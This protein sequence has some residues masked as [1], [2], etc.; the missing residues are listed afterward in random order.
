[1]IEVAAYSRREIDTPWGAPQAPCNCGRE[2]D[3]E[4]FRGMK[5]ESKRLNDTMC[6]LDVANKGTEGN[7]A[8]QTNKT[9]Y[10]FVLHQD[11][12]PLM[13]MKIGKAKK[14]IRSGKARIV[15]CKPL[16]IRLEYETTK[17]VDELTLGIDSGAVYIGYSLIN[18]RLK[19]E[20]ICG[21]LE[22]EH[23][24]SDSNPA[25]GRIDEKR[26][27][28][29]NRRSRLW[30]REARFDNRKKHIG[31][32]PPTIE[33]K[34]NT[35]KR[36]ISIIS[37]IA[38]VVHLV[39]EVAKFDIQK[40]KN[41]TIKGIEY[42]QGDLYGYANVKGFIMTREKCKCQLCGK[43]VLGY[44]VN[45][46]HIIPRSKGGTDKSNNLALLHEECHKRLHKEHLEETLARNKQYK[47][48]TFMSMINK[49]FW[50]DY[51]NMSV[52]YGNITFVNRC[53]FGIEKSH[54]NDAFII[55]GGDNSYSRS[56]EMD[57]GQKRRNDRQLQW[58]YVKKNK[59]HKFR[60]LREGRKSYHSGDLLLIDGKWVECKGMQNNSVVI[61][62]RK[63]IRGNNS[64]ITVSQKKITKSYRRAGIY[65]K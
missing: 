28:R 50:K 3:G 20:Y 32:L 51:P 57:L 27:Y 29:R 58:N 7:S 23:I 53:K 48:P 54:S 52:T 49:R 33:R 59:F 55:A 10:A 17:N 45:L 21:T 47:E 26:M 11:G 1:M 31:M 34:Y 35:H 38:P 46:H 60:R 41:T 42:Q 24:G 14:M 36:L 4:T 63:N 40:I 2:N 18:Q 9:T 25:K 61:G 43:S 30:Y 5:P 8:I 13:P 12:M 56:I 6:N 39:I 37:A 64:A 16:T 19:R 22:Q 65:F 44:K 62:F 15:K